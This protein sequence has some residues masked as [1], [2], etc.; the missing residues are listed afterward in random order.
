[1][2][3]YLVDIVPVLGRLTPIS[4]YLIIYDDCVPSGHS[5]S[6][7]KASSK[8]YLSIYLFMM[9]VYL[10]NI[11]VVLWRQAPSSIYLSMMTVYLVNIVLVLGRLTPRSIYLSI[12]DDYVPSGHSSSP[13]EASS[14]NYKSLFLHFKKIYKNINLSHNYKLSYSV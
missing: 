6:H 10:V 7:G 5:F 4:I 9:T 3:V 11:V 8:I 1:M 13:G 2:T 14:K 12:Y